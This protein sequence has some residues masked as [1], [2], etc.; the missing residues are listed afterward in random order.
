MMHVDAI[1]NTANPR[2]IVGGG[3]DSAIHKAAGLNFW[4]HGRK[5]AVLPQAKLQSL[6]LSTFAQNLSST[7]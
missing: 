5:S 7:Q 4:L 6:R 1:V 3:V 2:P